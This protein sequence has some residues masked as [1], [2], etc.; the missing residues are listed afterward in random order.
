MKNHR[1]HFWPG[2]AALALLTSLSVFGQSVAP[3]ITIQPS[4]QTADYGGNV[5][6]TFTA[7][8]AKLRYQWR[9]DGKELADYGNVSGAKTVTLQLVGVAQSDAGNYTVVIGNK[10][11]RVAS[12]AATLTVNS[13][14]V[15]SEDFEAGNMKNWT[16]FSDAS[17]LTNSTAQ[18][19][20]SGGSR[21][22]SLDDS[23]DRMYHNLNQELPG[24]VKVTFWIY[25]N[26]GSQRRYFGE[27]RGYSG[28]GHTT[29]VAPGGRRQTLAIGSYAIS[30]G[31]ANTGE[32]KNE[33]M[34]KTKYQG[35]V[36]RG[37]NIG[38]FNLSDAADRSVG[39]H[40]FEIVRLADGTTVK[41]YVDGVLSRTITGANNEPIDCV[42][43]GS[44]AQ[45]KFETERVYGQAWFD[46]IMV[47]AF[48]RQFDWQS[49]DSKGDGVFDWVKVRE[50]KIDPSVSDTTQI[51]TVAEVN[52]AAMA[53]SLGTWTNDG[54]GICA[55]N[56]RGYVEYTINA[57][58]DDAYRIEVEGRERNFTFPYIEMPLIVSID[59]E[60]LGRFNLA[61]GKQTN[62]FVRCF[63]P[64]IRAG[65]HT[66]R[67]DWD[68]ADGYASLYL[69]L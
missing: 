1:K 59:G 39:W 2:L 55:T 17:T 19:H 9:K 40:K 51:T 11:G 8:G 58:A 41:F 62:G 5:T 49:K 25:D 13:T 69:A 60:Y 26:G 68:N 43:L 28:N 66:V 20:T 12:S 35:R 29:Y 65:A 56:M 54:S 3:T 6:F 42:V 38:W 44:T 52:G 53:A 31:K 22:A 21:S 4:H 46:D 15:F 37:K 47:E 23:F 30:F 63:T 34:D 36:E 7:S 67:I 50:M 27:V 64:F 48:P 45:K 61:Y 14:T 33:V 32:L 57:P 18:N 10:S 16:R 24:R